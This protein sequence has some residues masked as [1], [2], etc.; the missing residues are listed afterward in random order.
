MAASVTGAGA[1]N[2][3]H[4]LLRAFRK[5]IRAFMRLLAGLRPLWFSNLFLA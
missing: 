4:T 5:P 3:D 2:A 1:S